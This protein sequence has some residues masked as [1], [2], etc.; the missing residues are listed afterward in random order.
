MAQFDTFRFSIKYAQMPPYFR[1]GRE[2]CVVSKHYSGKKGKLIWCVSSTKKS[3]A[4]SEPTI[5]LEQIR[6]NQRVISRDVFD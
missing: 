1:N 5:S 2:P 6:T 4:T 3:Q